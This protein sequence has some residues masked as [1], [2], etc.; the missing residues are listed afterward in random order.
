MQRD[1]NKKLHQPYRLS[2]TQEKTYSLIPSPGP[3]STLG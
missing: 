2:A 3:L 1:S